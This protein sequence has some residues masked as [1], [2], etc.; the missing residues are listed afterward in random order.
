MT[1]QGASI[2]F[3]S[4]VLEVVEKLTNKLAIIQKGK[5]IANGQTK[6]ILKDQTLESFFMELS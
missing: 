6:M 5:L 4:H 1:Q 2:F 3:S